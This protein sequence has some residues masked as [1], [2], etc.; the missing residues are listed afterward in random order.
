MKHILA[1]FNE[2]YRAVLSW[3]QE[4]FPVVLHLGFSNFALFHIINVVRV[5]NFDAKTVFY[6]I[7]GRESMKKNE[8]T[9]YWRLFDDI[10]VIHVATLHCH[11]SLWTY[12]S[13]WHSWLIQNSSITMVHQD[14]HFRGFSHTL[15]VENGWTCSLESH[16]YTCLCCVSYYHLNQRSG[17]Q[18]FLIHL[19][20]ALLILL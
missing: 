8:S 3:T 14:Q 19:F 11:C 9:A 18:G 20:W 4:L 5:V 16:K 10:V 13:V 17:N 7:G 2:M 1:Q 6:L 15:A 12:L